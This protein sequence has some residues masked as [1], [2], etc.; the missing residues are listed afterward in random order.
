MTDEDDLLGFDADMH[1]PAQRCRHGTFIGSWWGPDYLC[2]WCES[3]TDPA[4]PEPAP[5]P[6]T[7]ITMFYDAGG[8][9]RY[10]LSA[11]IGEEEF[12]LGDYG[13]SADCGRAMVRWLSDRG[14]TT[15]L[16]SGRRLSEAQRLGSLVIT[17]DVVR[18]EA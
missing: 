14:L 8:D 10:H 16:G 15:A 2:G 12:D 3:G 4:L 11:D 7:T 13:D 5:L 1:D 9:G 17:L 18:H 6:P